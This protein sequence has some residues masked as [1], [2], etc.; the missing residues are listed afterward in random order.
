M[1][2]KYKKILYILVYIFINIAF[3]SYLGVEQARADVDNIFWGGQ[4]TNIQASLGLG[5]TDP[6]Y[7]IANVVNIA[8][9]FIGIIAVMI[10]MMAGFKLMTTGG[11]EDAVVEAKRMMSSGVIGLVIV[12]SSFGLAQFV[13]NNLFIVTGA[14]D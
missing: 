9:G 12:F 4:T 6:R 5:N 13:V 2:F 14:I 1:D 3:V 8:L 11:N 10:I 7:M